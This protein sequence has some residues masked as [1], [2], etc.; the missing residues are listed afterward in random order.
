M[1]LISSFDIGDDQLGIVWND[2]ATSRYPWLWVRDHAH[3]EATLHPVTQQRQLHTAGVRRDLRGI[4][5]NIVGEQVEV[6]WSDG[7]PA[8]GW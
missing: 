2:G 6:K 8:T 1:T 5:A 7:T 4:A 3:D